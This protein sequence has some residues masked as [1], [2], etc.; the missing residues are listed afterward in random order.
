MCPH[1]VA[2][3]IFSLAWLPIYWRQL[4]AYAATL[5]CRILSHDYAET[6]GHTVCNRCGECRY[7]HGNPRQ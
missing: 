6:D 5:L 1:C 4:R 3:A 2:V 7:C